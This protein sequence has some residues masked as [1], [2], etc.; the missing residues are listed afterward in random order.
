MVHYLEEKEIGKEGVD[1]LLAMQQ[2]HK[3]GAPRF[4]LHEVMPIARC[5]HMTAGAAMF[6]MRTLMTHELVDW[7]M[8]EE[9]RGKHLVFFLTKKGAEFN[10]T[11]E[12]LAA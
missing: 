6:V 12:L 9:V 3:Q 5:A 10:P 2:L 4:F 1:F 11:N 8:I 7:Q